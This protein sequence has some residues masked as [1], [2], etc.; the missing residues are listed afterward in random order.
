MYFRGDYQW[1]V[2]GM[3]F[4]PNHTGQQQGQRQLGGSSLTEPQTENSAARAPARV[5]FTY[6]TPLPFHPYLRA[7]R[8]RNGPD[9]S[10]IS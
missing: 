9:W 4:N 10:Q 8:S 3:R 2:P 5:V 6:A 1:R 7:L